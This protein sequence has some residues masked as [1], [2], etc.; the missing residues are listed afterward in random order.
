MT[1]CVTSSVLW[2]LLFRRIQ[3]PRFSRLLAPIGKIVACSLAMGGAAFW[4]W[5]RVAAFSERVAGDGKLAQILSMGVVVFVAM[6]V[7]AGLVALVDIRLLREV[8]EDLRGR[9]KRK[10]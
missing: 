9:R 4:I 2:F 8:A 10:R 1:S 5:P 6:A 3:T 7:Y